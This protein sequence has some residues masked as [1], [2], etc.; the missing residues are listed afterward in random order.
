MSVPPVPPAAL[1]AALEA[2]LRTP[3]VG[4]TVRPEAAPPQVRAAGL[5]HAH[6][7][8]T[9]NLRD[10]LAH[11]D[12][13]H[14]A[15]VSEAVHAQDGRFLREIFAARYGGQPEWFR[16]SWAAPAP[17]PASRLPLLFYR[18]AIPFD[19]HVQ[20]RP[21]LPAPEP[22][23]LANWREPPEVPASRGAPGAAL[24]L[25]TTE[26]AAAADLAAVLSL[27]AVGQLRD[28]AK[29]G[30]P[31]DASQRTVAGVLRHGDFYPGVPIAA[32]AW[33]LMVQAG[34]LVHTPGPG[35]AALI[36][37]GQPILRHLWHRWLDAGIIDECLRVDGI[38]GKQARRGLNLTPPRRR[39]VASA[40]AG[41][42]VGSWIAV[43]DFR[44]YM[45][46][47]RHT[48]AVVHDPV[49]HTQRSTGRG[50]RA[51]TTRCGW[52]SRAG[53]CC[54]CCWSTPRRSGCSTSPSAPRSAPA[55]TSGSCGEAGRS[56]HSAATTGSMPSGSRASAPTVW[57][58]R[59]PIPGRTP[60]SRPVVPDR[61]AGRRTARGHERGPRRP[62]VTQGGA[63]A[64]RPAP[65]TSP[66]GE[67]TPPQAR[68]MAPPPEVALL[69]GV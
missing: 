41:C 54:A 12:A 37:G 3:A 61:T 30:H 11:L 65:P 52:W 5:L 9:G 17:T 50:S 34:G 36:G 48:F 6:L 20:L 18:G 33:A 56:L 14:R 35:S 10:L 67:G 16:P 68:V 1:R 55:T 63:S 2:G 23:V 13:R 53:T 64:V 31:S 22:F 43:D 21:L 49:S 40:P 29:T 47:Q 57:A 26:A 7:S 42:P 58:A 60:P 8:A 27:C 59:R 51:T 66:P 38:S 44:R 25:R 45:R 62:R 32:F 24:T 46:V 28:G 15:T 69:C 4:G 39:A 19:L